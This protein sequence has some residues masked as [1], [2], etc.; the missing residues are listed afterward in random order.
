MNVRSFR[1]PDWGNPSARLH[2]R[3]FCQVEFCLSWP[4]FRGTDRTFRRPAGDSRPIPP[5]VPR[6]F[7]GRRNPQECLSIPLR[8]V[9]TPG[10]P[11]LRRR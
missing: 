7:P 4:L 1:I 6:R 5:E 11:L 8:M 9:F 10:D 2:K 3:A